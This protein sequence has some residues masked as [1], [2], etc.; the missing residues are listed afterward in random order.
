MLKIFL[1]STSHSLN[2]AGAIL[3]IF[4]LVPTFLCTYISHKECAK[5]ITRLMAVQKRNKSHIRFSQDFYFYKIRST[6]TTVANF[7]FCIQVESLNQQTI[8][9]L[10]VT[11]VKQIFILSGK[12]TFVI[13]QKENSI[14][15]TLNS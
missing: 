13:K 9:V 6:Q 1:Y 4:V 15:Y 14:H 3:V 8:I 10:S 12:K 7:W 11:T 2:K 5:V